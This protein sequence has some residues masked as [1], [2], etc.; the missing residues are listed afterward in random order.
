MEHFSISLLSASVSFAIEVSEM[1][2]I[3]FPVSARAVGLQQ[4]T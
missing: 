1:P 4:S 3:L 2:A